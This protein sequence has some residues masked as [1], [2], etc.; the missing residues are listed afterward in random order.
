METPA[1]I[2]TE[3]AQPPEITPLSKHK[4]NL[5]NTIGTPSTV[6]ENVTSTAST[7][8]TV[9]ENV[10]STASTHSTVKE[11][12]TSTA[13]TQ[14]TVKENV[15][16][17]ASTHS[18]VKENVT[19]TA[20]TQSTVKKTTK[21]KTKPLYFWTCADVNKWLKKHCS[22]F[23]GIYGDLLL[24]QEVTGR[25]LIRMNEIKL[26]RIGI[27]KAEH[28]NEFMQYI[29]RLRLRHETGDLKNLD[30]KGTGFELKLPEKSRNT[31]EMKEKHPP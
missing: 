22:Q 23:H 27:A 3:V 28:R 12:V 11:S 18:T 24:Q 16:S 25:T 5:T 10:T 6:K 13:S 9:K 14:S 19:S 15:T 20:S 26:E 1:V 8:S 2:R 30:Q 4:E 17:T 7:H 31:K 21:S 29:L